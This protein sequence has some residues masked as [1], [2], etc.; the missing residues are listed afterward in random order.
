MG[1]AMLQQEL[2]TGEPP[3]TGTSEGS[4][5]PAKGSILVVEDDRN[6]RWV[7][8]ELLKDEGY[9]VEV[10][11]HGQEAIEILLHRSFSLILLDLQMPV[12]DGWMFLRKRKHITNILNIPV[13][14]LSGL[15]C[16]EYG[17]S[18]VLSK[19]TD[20]SV[21]LECVE[22]HIRGELGHKVLG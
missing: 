15:N 18:E 14:V 4:D 12:M 16:D 8:E 19:P 13:V 2:E 11:C 10:A 7:L 21:L 22:R 5:L 20:V 3:T 1:Y 17:V 9:E 6:V